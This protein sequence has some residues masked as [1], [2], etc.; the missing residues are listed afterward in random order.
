LA[1]QAKTLDE[2]VADLEV[3]VSWLA[4]RLTQATQVEE[5]LKRAKQGT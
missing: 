3:T 1:D 5:I 2:R 4:E